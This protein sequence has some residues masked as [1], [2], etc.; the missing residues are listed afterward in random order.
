MGILINDLEELDS[1]YL[2]LRLPSPQVTFSLV[3]IGSSL[4]DLVT[5]G[6]A[7]RGVEGYGFVMQIV[8]NKTMNG[9]LWRAMD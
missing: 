2:Y 9:E 4:V 8:M 6:G 3:D 5:W 1:T 7:W